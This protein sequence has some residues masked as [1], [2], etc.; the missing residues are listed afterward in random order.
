M[1]KKFITL[2]IF[3]GIL[4]MFVPQMSAQQFEYPANKDK[5]FISE[6]EFYQQLDEKVYQ[7]FKDATFSIRQ[8]IFYKE[9]PDELMA[10]AKKTGR[11]LSQ[12][13]KNLLPFIHPDRQVYFLASFSD[14]K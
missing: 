12:T 14:K 10:F 4:F 1:V 11:S 13:Q 8:K 2:I 5:S 3:F 9:T 7:E 6:D